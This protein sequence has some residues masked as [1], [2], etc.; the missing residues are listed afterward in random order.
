[1]ILQNS[2]AIITGGASGLGQAT[3]Q[4]FVNQGAKVAIFDLQVEAG[5]AFAQTL[6]DSKSKSESET[7][8][9]RF[10][11]VDVS[12]EDQVRTAIAETRKDLGEIRICINC[13]GIVT[14]GKTLGRKGPLDLNVFSK[15]IE[16][17]LIGSFNLIR[18][19]AEAMATN[20]PQS[21][22]QQAS[23]DGEKGVSINTASV[24]AFDG[25]IGQAAY[26]ASKAGIVGMTLPIARDLGPHGIR[27]NTIA[28]GVI[29]TPMM[30]GMPEEVRKPLEDMVQ[31]PKRLGHPEEFAKLAAHIVDNAYINGETIRLDGGIRMPPK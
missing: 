4:Y 7:P 19:V 23:S 17:N 5:K 11:Q 22:D 29:N 14:P 6:C 24:A 25:Q 2:V 26:S 13:A 20:Q 16:I 9:A 12:N 31:F 15:V 3:S 18:L 28:P 21:D 10:Y 8:C 1:M 27:V 30:Q